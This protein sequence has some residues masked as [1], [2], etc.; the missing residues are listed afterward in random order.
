MTEKPLEDWTCVDVVVVVSLFA[1][2]GGLTCL[3][4][5]FLN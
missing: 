5:A 4:A 1:L 3:V 2:F